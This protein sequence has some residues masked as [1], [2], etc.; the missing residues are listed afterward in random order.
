MPFMFRLTREVRFGLDGEAPPGPDALL[1]A[2]A[3]APP[4]RGLGRFC[5]VR[6]TVAGEL[7]ASTGYLMNIKRIDR[8]V[9]DVAIGML[10][11]AAHGQSLDARIVE[12]LLRAVSA[13]LAPPPAESL[14]LRLSPFLCLSALAGELPMVRISQK[15]D[16]SAAHR[17]HNPAF[18]DEQNRAV[19]GKCSNP[20]GHGHNYEL[21]V[22]LRG[23]PDERG[24][25]I[26]VPAFERIVM[27]H[28]IQR[29]DHRN[30]NVEVSEFRNL[31]PTVENIAATIYRLLKPHFAEHRARLASV[32]VWETP[33][34]W[35]EYSE[36][37]G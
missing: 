20:H 16:F 31:N 36:P 25:L 34:T 33:R 19:F 9:R 27:E 14:V 29:L 32:T 7:E 15:F 13:A 26:D 37:E 2:F 28:V 4:V 10:A 22:T 18:S 5:V 21:Q 11:T 3:A 23:E 1:N 35:C 12:R 24:L 17:L 6:L 8:A 30:L